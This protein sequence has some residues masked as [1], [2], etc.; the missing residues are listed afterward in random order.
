MKPIY[1]DHAATTPLASEAY[2]AMQPWLQ[3]HYGNPASDHVFGRLAKQGVERARAQVAALLGA[4][5]EEILFTSGATESNNLAIKGALEFRGLEGAHLVT[6]RT[7]HKCVLDTVRYLESRGLRVTWLKPDATGVIPVE[8]VLAALTPATAM[9]SLMWVNNELGSI[10][11]V[12]QLAPMLRERGVLFH[13]DAVQAAGK[14]AINLAETPIDLLSVSAHKLYGP[15]GVGA[16]FVRKRPRARL[17][18]QMHGG[19][20]EQGMRSGTLAPHQIAGMGEA[21]RL[22]AERQLADAAHYAAL[23]DR[24]WARLSALPRVLRNGS[25]AGAP[26]ILNVSFAGVEGEALRAML[27]ALMI[28]SGSACSSATR[29]PSY[30]LRALGRDDALANASLRFSLGRANTEAEIDRAAAQVIEAVLWLRE[31]NG[32]PAGEGAAPL[33]PVD[34]VYEYPPAVWQHFSSAGDHAGQFPEGTPGLLSLRA[35]NR[36]AASTLGLQLRLGDDGRVSEARFQALGCPVGIAVGS[37]LAGQ[38]PGLTPAELSALDVRQL[39]AALEIPED[40]L[41]CALMGEDLLRQIP[42]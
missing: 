42:V 41:H 38:A 22:A 20:H 25:A 37:W 23:R 34:N 1:L 27:P 31:I 17:S 14:L 35:E 15:K 11:P 9:V 6:A 16:L 26:H 18:P 19:G 5:S 33:P 40:K 13:V 32:E 21:F 4:T 7:E 2:A 36:A 3:E 24:L 30:V 28:S 29:E 10:N 39:R 8:A 12:E